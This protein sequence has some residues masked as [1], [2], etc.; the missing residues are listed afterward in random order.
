M[1]VRGRKT[2]TREEDARF[3]LT[4]DIWFDVEDTRFAF[5]FGATRSTETRDPG[6]RVSRFTWVVSEPRDPRT[7][8]RD[9]HGDMV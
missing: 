2:R 4:G 9:I 1:T 6:T 5:C 8:F 3:F 7:R